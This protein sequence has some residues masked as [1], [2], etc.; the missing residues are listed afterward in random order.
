MYSLVSNVVGVERLWRM[1][2]ARGVFCYLSVS[3]QWAESEGRYIALSSAGAGPD[4]WSK[5]MCV[6]WAGS[7]GCFRT[8][9]SGHFIHFS[10]SKSVLALDH[11]DFP[12]TDIKS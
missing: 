4:D 11:C 6:L 8:G 7:T 2:E 12:L 3:S 5:C 9:V 10:V 1:F